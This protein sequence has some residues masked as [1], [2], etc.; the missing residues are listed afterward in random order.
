MP[1]GRT[2]V[3]H[4][5]EEGRG[6]V[7]RV[8][9]AALGCN[10]KDRI[11]LRRFGVSEPVGTL[12]PCDEL[13]GYIFENS[14]VVPAEL[15]AADRVIVVHAPGGQNGTIDKNDRNECDLATIGEQR[16]MH[17]ERRQADGEG[18][19][20]AKNIEGL[21]QGNGPENEGRRRYADRGSGDQKCPAIRE[22]VVIQP[23]RHPLRSRA[24]KPG[25]EAE[26]EAGKGQYAGH[27]LKPK[28]VCLKFAGLDTDNAAHFHHASGSG[29]HFRYR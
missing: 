9:A 6:I 19:D 14:G 16:D 15:R 12:Q 23:C 22:I 27:H 3:L 13:V 25:N 5:C 21:R 1:E 18:S 7:S 17:N 8:G 4:A 2:E 28:R 26:S 10:D 24:D 29:R 20:N 11:N